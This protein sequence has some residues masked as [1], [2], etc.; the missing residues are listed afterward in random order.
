MR[1]Y[2]SFCPSYKKGNILS[3]QFTSLRKMIILLI[4]LLTCSCAFSNSVVYNASLTTHRACFTKSSKNPIFDILNALYTCPKN[5]PKT[6]IIL[7]PGVLH[8]ACPNYSTKGRVAAGFCSNQSRAH[9][10]TNQ[11]SQDWDQL[12][13]WVR[14]S[15]LLLSWKENLQPHDPL[16]NSLDMAVLHRKCYIKSFILNI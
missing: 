11:L 14:S 8:Q 13:K 15:A 6:Q 2:S 9:S 3:K 12:I 1:R 5:A 16:W 4:F 7:A 10:L